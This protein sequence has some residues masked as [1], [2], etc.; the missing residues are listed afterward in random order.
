MGA[1]RSIWMTQSV[2][3]SHGMPSPNIGPMAMMLR[4]MTN[5]SAMMR[6]L[7][8]ILSAATSC[9]SASSRSSLI[10]VY[11]AASTALRMSCSDTTASS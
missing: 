7:L 3:V 10:I 6:S 11:P 9:L 4:G 8:W 5:M 1:K 2:F